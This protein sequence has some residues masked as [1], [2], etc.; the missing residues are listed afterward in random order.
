ML[1]GGQPTTII[2]ALPD[3]LKLAKKHDLH[4]RLLG[5]D[6]LPFGHAVPEHLRENPLL[7]WSVCP[8]DVLS[9][10]HVQAVVGL[11][12]MSKVAP[13]SGWPHDYAAWAVSGL[14]ALRAHRGE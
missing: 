13:L 7:N 6:R 8:M 10:G 9:C 4:R 2:S 5:C 3:L 1:H 12:R 11:D 14:M